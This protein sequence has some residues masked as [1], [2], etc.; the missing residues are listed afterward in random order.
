MVDFHKNA[1]R[2]KKICY[3][4]S[5]CENCQRQSYKAF[6]GLTNR[7]KII[8]GGDPLYLKFWIKVTAF[9]QNRWFSIYCRS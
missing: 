2:L 7:A 5:L 4:V 6:I 9:V 8:G 1:L 3:K